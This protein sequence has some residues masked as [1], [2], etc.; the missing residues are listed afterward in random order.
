LSLLQSTSVASR[1]EG[2]WAEW[3]RGE[4]P[5][6]PTEAVDK[7]LSENDEFGT[8]PPCLEFYSNTTELVIGAVQRNCNDVPYYRKCEEGA[9]QAVDSPSRDSLHLQA[10]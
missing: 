8:D 9:H 7:F 4:T 1:P 3:A 5:A 6:W 2:Y 10:L